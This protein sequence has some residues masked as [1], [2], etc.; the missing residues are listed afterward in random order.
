MTIPHL[1]GLRRGSL[2]VV[3]LALCLC[4]FMQMLG[5]P[6]TLLSAEDISDEYSGSALEGFSLPQ[7]FPPLTLSSES[8]SAVE[9]PQS[10][11]LFVLASQQF[12]PPAN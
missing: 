3:A 1:V 11:H 10:A 5:A 4:V 12:H 2:C 7:T 6:G 9:L 8:L